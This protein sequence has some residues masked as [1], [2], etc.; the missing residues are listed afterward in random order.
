[1]RHKIDLFAL[2]TVAL[3]IVGV[4]YSAESASGAPGECSKASGQVKVTV[5]VEKS[6]SESVFNYRLINT[7]RNDIYGFLVGDGDKM[8]LIGDPVQDI[9]VIGSP[10]RWKGAF[11]QKYE[12]K[13]AHV[14][15][16]TEKSIFLRPNESAKGFVVRVRSDIRPVKFEK[17]PLTVSFRNGKCVWLRPCVETK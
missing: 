11:R 5:K 6:D 1:M 3:F 17:L 14:Y 10:N 2:A 7:S 15:W 12:S 16:H 9:A 4:A 8:E 13:Y